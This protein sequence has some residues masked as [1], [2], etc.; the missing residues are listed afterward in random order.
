M[1]PMLDWHGVLSGQPLQWIISGF[2]TTVWVSVAGILLATLLAVLLLALR[3]GGGR[4]G[5]GLV[6]AWVSLF[7]NT[8]LLVQLLFWYFAA[9]NLLPLAVKKVVNDEHAWSILPGN[10]WWL[11]PEFLCSMWG[12]G[13]FTSAFLVEEIASGLRAVSHGQREAALSQGFTPWQELRF[14]LLPQGLANAWQ[15]IVGQYLNLM[16]LSSLASGIGFAELTY[17]LRQ[18]ESYNA[19]ALEAFAVGTAL[20][21]ALGVAMGV[22]LTRLGPGRKLQRSAQ[23][24]R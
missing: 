9:W 11:T 21:L 10:V 23:H 5:R 16:K 3:L 7:R 17:Q 6:A 12:L 15:P 19:H 4:A 22:A 1:T 13:V 20:Y 18:I 24:E 8:P 2:L 14:I